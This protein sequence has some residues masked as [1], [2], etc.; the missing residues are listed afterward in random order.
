MRPC[1]IHLLHAVEIYLCTVLIALTVRQWRQTTSP[2]LEIT[3]MVV[4]STKGSRVRESTLS[5]YLSQY[6]RQMSWDRKLLYT[7]I[8]L[9]RKVD[10]LSRPWKM[11]NR[12]HSRDDKMSQRGRY[13]ACQWWGTPEVC[14]P[15]LNADNDRGSRKGVWQFWTDTSF[16]PAKHIPLPWCAWGGMGGGYEKWK[17]ALQQAIFMNDILNDIC[18]HI[19]QRKS[20]KSYL[21]NSSTHIYTHS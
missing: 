4:T 11:K 10:A 8:G 17:T 19:R 7:F 18:S 3:A 20:T 14:L 9:A 15:F 12:K 13:F 21:N 16:H 1:L 5:L 6:L 2:R